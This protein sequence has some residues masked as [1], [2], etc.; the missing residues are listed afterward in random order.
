MAS[1]FYCKRCSHNRDCHLQRE[2]DEAG[3]QTSVKQ[4]ACRGR[5]TKPGSPSCQCPG[6]VRV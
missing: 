2:Y 3:N 5:T 6:F 4:V 1:P